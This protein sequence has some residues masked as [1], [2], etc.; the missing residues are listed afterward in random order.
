MRRLALTLALIFLALAARAQEA[1]PAA[2]PAP[3][4]PPEVAPIELPRIVAEADSAERFARSVRHGLAPSAEILRV[5]RSLAE[6]APELAQRAAGA[7]SL[8]TGIASLDAVNAEMRAA[9]LAALQLTRWL[10]EPTAALVSIERSLHELDMQSEVW[11]R[12]R[13]HAR[14][15]QAPAEALARI[16]AVRSALRGATREAKA[17]RSGLL[18][19]QARIANQESRVEELIDLLGAA[20][21]RAQRSLLERDSEPL[22][23]SF[24]TQSHSAELAGRQL[25]RD[26]AAARAYA[27]RTYAPF[28]AQLA[29]FV[30]AALLG[31]YS[32]RRFENLR[33]DPRLAASAVIFERAFSSAALM[34]LSLTSALHPLAPS[35]VLGVSRLALI[36]PVLRLLPKLV[37]EALQPA[38]WVV[39]ALAG[40]DVLRGAL[41]TIAPLERTLFTLELAAAVGALLWLMR[42]ARLVLVPDSANVP[43]LLQLPL[44]LALLLFGVAFVASVL[45]WS[46]L[47][48]LLGNGTLLSTYAAVVVYGGARVLRAGLRA[49]V[50]TG[51]DANVRLL[52]ENA[53]PTIA[54]GAR[55]VNIA[56]L[57]AWAALTLRAFG[58]ASDFLAF[59]GAIWSTPVGYGSLEIALGDVLTFVL[60]IWA[61]V[62]LSR[63][64]RFVVE[65]E[66]LSRFK[67][68]GGVAHAVAR[69]AQYLIVLLGFFAAAAAAG[70][71]MNRF[72]VLAGAF[73]VG[74]G[75]GLQNI[76]NNFVSGLILL[77]ERPIQIGDSIEVS[78]GISGDVKSLGIRS[79]TL[80][81]F[82][83]ADVIVPNAMLISEKVTNWTLS[84]RTRR[85][86]LKIGVAY[87]SDPRRVLELLLGCAR[88][89]ASVLGY[90]EPIALFTGFGE[91][92]L[93]FELRFWTPFDDAVPARSAVGLAVHDTLTGAGIEIP[94]PQRDLRLRSV[95]P[96]AAQALRNRGASD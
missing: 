85:N 51:A 6:A 46:N 9:Q 82:E 21:A 73:G 33:G 93:S 39:A 47:A 24:G 90:P 38:I 59:A 49:A 60:T 63:F 25:A 68:S 64:V 2:A 3:A 74:I 77:Y 45:G 12:T 70:I 35:F 57:C 41:V 71:D 87:G 61:S 37:D 40:I 18:D 32:N 5:E 16:D 48:R 4:P 11:E 79:C 55:V 19:L 15:D 83:G 17:A 66:A 58:F 23:S 1:A 54:G 96:E 36:P 13:E 80:R 67:P 89:H 52:R 29:I 26:S 42:P 75:F 30:G 84:D 27:K 53:E 78:G 76:V 8:A 50:R 69:T 86:D 14:G 56:A 7:E 34:A 43:R 91:S 88:A 81:T 92:A 22:W 10:R 20:K 95:A 44:Q 31:L 94:F 65:G 72:S 28:V 62:L